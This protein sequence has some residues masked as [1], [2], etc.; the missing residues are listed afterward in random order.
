VKKKTNWPF[1][2]IASGITVVWQIYEIST[3]TE[4]LRQALAILQYVV[5]GLAAISC[6]GSIGM[7][8]SGKP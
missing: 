2:I 7:Y 5:V 1:F 6:I 8:L 3:A 4:A